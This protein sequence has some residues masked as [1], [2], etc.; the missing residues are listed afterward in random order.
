MNWKKKLKELES[1]LNSE[2]NFNEYVLQSNLNSEENFNEYAKCNS[3][4]ELIYEKIAEGVKLE[5]NVN[6]MEKM[7]IQLNFFLISNE[8]DPL[9]RWSEN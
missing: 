9:K 5:A 7:K 3:D 8:N 4:L 2:E 1:N 6:G